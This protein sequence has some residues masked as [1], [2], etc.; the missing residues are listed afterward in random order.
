MF[1]TFF[2]RCP[3]P[4]PSYAFTSLAIQDV[5]QFSQQALSMTLWLESFLKGALGGKRSFSCGDWSCRSPAA[6]L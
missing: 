6:S 5:V 4:P 1:F 3:L 2:A